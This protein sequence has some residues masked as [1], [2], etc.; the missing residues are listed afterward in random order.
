M[1]KFVSENS[2]KETQDDQFHGLWYK[3][4]AVD[5]CTIQEME[6]V[7]V[8]VAKHASC[9]SQMTYITFHLLSICT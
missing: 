9:E 3:P 5:W 8:F 4:L 7:T 2:D 6:G 1:E